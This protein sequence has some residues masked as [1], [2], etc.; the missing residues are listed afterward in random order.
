MYFEVL[1]L[2]IQMSKLASMA[3]C[4]CGF[5]LWYPRYQENWNRKLVIKFISSLL[6]QFSP[7]KFL[8]ISIWLS[9]SAKL[10]LHCC[11]DIITVDLYRLFSTSYNSEDGFM[12]E[13]LAVFEAKDWACI[14]DHLALENNDSKSDWHGDSTNDF[15]AADS[16]W[17]YCSFCIRKV[18]DF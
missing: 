4:F 1:F 6:D 5:V 8:T 15:L 14:L 3:D 11:W 7:W 12:K 13:V 9:L 18:D 2:L 16:W 17:L 10:I